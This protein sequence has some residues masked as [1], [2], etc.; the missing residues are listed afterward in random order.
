MLHND[1]DLQHTNQNLRLVINKR[2]VANVYVEG[3]SFGHHLFIDNLRPYLDVS[4]MY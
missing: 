4:T 1:C 2:L 3:M